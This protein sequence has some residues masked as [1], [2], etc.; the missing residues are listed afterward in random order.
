MLPYVA[1]YEDTGLWN[2]TD[3]TPLSNPACEDVFKWFIQS[4]VSSV[5]SLWLVLMFQNRDVAGSNPNMTAA[6]LESNI[7][8][9]FTA[10]QG[11][12]RRHSTSEKH[13]FP[14]LCSRII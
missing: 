13:S 10:A 12:P 14:I 5:L 6:E 1:F 4:D 7:L 11:M 2:G 9:A 3:V 8:S